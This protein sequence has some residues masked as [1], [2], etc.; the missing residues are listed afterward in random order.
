MPL[1]DN[2]AMRLTTAR[3]YTPSGRS[4]QALG[5]SLTLL[6]NSQT[7]PLDETQEEERQA[8]NE[9]DLRGSLDNDSLT[10]ERNQIKADRLAAEKS[11]ELREQDYQLAYAIDLLK[12]FALFRQTIKRC[13]PPLCITFPLG[14]S[15]K[16][17]PNVF[18]QY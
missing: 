2:A 1:R 13:E 15:T 6:W 5:V 9:S 17:K 3:Y 10:E 4:I 7:P 18:D 11:A 12:G 16:E 8:R 14:A